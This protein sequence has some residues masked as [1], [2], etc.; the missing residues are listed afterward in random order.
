MSTTYSDLNFT[1]Y[2]DQCDTYEYMQDISIDTYLLAK[3]YQSLISQ[4]K[5]DEAA[6]LLEDN[7]SLNRSTLN[8]EK[9]NKLIDSIKAIERLYF[10]DVQTYIM[11]LVSYKGDFSTTKKYSKYDVVSYTDSMTYM[12]ISLNCPLGTSPTD[13]A[14]WIPLSIKGDQGVSGTGL[15]PRGVWDS[16]IQYYKDDLVSYNNQLWAAKEDNISSLPNDNSSIWYSVLYLDVTKD[17][18]NAKFNES[19]NYVD[20][21]YNELFQSVSDGKT[22]VASAITDKGI[23]TSSDAT[24]ATMANNISLIETGIHTTDATATADQILENCTA[25]VNDN[26]ITG[27]MIDFSKASNGDDVVSSYY[28]AQPIVNTVGSSA[29][30]Y[31]TWGANEDKEGMIVAPKQGYYPNTSDSTTSYLYIPADKIAAK[32]KISPYKIVKGYTICGVEGTG[33]GKWQ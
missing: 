20:T 27:T 2:P 9:Y 1:Q 8:A 33:V 22:V 4:S 24:F 28:S 32:L 26:K 14:Y 13:A 23:T 31:G 7:P 25:Y 17:Y 21:K 3:Q 19:K 5:F 11:E 16:E 18:V 6:Q 30:Q 15:S 10:S 12:C 29:V